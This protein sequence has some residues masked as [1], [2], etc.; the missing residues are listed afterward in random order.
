M[1]IR[2]ELHGKRVCDSEEFY[3][4]Y[5]KIECLYIHFNCLAF[6]QVMLPIYGQDRIESKKLYC[7]MRSKL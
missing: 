4:V 2:E 6:L 7:F 1:S 3:D 5:E